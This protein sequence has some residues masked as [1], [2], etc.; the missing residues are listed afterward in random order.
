MTRPLRYKAISPVKK[1]RQNRKR[2]MVRSKEHISSQAKNQNQITHRK[3]QIFLKIFE[4]SN[5]DY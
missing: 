2:I 4:F 1:L 3:F 5:S